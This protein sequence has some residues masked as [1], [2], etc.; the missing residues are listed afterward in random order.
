MGLSL[1]GFS[2]PFYWGLL[3]RLLARMRANTGICSSPAKSWSGLALFLL[4]VR[5][6]VFL[7]L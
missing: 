6:G 2:S 1:A 3:P 4:P 5:W 7:L